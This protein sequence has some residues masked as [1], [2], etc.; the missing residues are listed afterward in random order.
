MARDESENVS[1]THLDAT[2]TCAESILVQQSAFLVAL[3][4]WRVRWVCRSFFWV[5]LEEKIRKIK[6]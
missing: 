2:P 6:T 1:P 4:E 3:V 5:E